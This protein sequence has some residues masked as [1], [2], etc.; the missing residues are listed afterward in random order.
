MLAP[1]PSPRPPLPSPPVPC[2]S[3]A[4]T[5]AADSRVVASL[6]CGVWLSFAA[7]RLG[8]SLPHP[9]PCSELLTLH[10]LLLL[11]ALSSS[12]RLEGSSRAS[13]RFVA[14][15]RL[16]VSPQLLPESWRPLF[17]LLRFL[18]PLL[19][20]LLLLLLFCW[21]PPLPP[22]LTL[23]PPHAVAAPTAAEARLPGEASR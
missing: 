16:A 20:L 3:P 17:P 23:P 18:P 6:R 2:S 11:L 10:L 12:A 14:G 4:P 5:H 15:P 9:F 19:L 22:P 8:S 7:P 13:T 21:S 1:P